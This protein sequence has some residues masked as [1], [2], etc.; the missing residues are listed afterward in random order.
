MSHK[1]KPRPALLLLPL[2]LLLLLLLQA[3]R[4]PDHVLLGDE[5]FSPRGVGLPDAGL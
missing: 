5:L 1:W 2:S 3:Q 4:F